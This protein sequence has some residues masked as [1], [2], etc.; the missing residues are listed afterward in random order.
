MTV[1]LSIVITTRDRRA[2]LVQLLEDLALS[3]PS[4]GGGELLV[5]DNGSTDGT[6]GA[7]AG[8]TRIGPYPFHVL[9]EPVA[10][11]SAARNR[12]IAGASGE[13][14]LFLDD[15]VRVPPQWASRL[16]AGL[17]RLSAEAGGGR[18]DPTWPPKLPRWVATDPARIER[19]V[20]VQYELGSASRVLDPVD[21]TPVGCNMAFRR[22]VLA[23]HGGFM[24]TLGHTGRR[25]MGGDD[26]EMFARLRAAGTRLGY[27]ADAAVTHP[28]SPDRLT[29]GY[30]LRRRYWEG[31]GA[32]GHGS[33]SGRS[34]ARVP[35]A[36]WRALGRNLSGA[37]GAAARTDW[38]AAAHHL[39]G[40]AHR[41]GY[42]VGRWARV[43]S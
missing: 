29:L 4:P 13:W 36:A 12:A 14:I 18:V 27:V 40:V 41:A 35:S 24:T 37:I 42:A 25:L 21:P 33:P 38:P 9:E 19:I 39:G 11:Q 16:V 28:V 32:A 26:A 8:R 20:F 22:E 7:L 34:L 15:D 6:A 10:G 43:R 31:F 23:T 17:E 1:K 30:L 2:T 5:V 3:L